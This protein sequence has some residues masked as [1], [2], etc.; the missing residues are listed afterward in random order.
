MN[1]LKDLF[2]TAIAVVLLLA[3]VSLPTGNSTTCAATKS[4]AP[5]RGYYLT[6]GS[7]DGSHALT[8]CATGFHM[9][10]LYE[11]H[12]PSNLSYDTTLGETH[13]DDG[14]GPPQDDSGWIRTGLGIAD[15]NCAIWT[16]NSS[17][18]QGTTVGLLDPLR[19]SG[20]SSTTDLCSNSNHVWCVQN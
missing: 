8:A 3:M 6:A 11:I 12:E 2:R 15:A 4:T 5:V 10:S 17:S 9:A 16:S 20:W 7:F 19:G 14:E 13:E 18:G 1:S